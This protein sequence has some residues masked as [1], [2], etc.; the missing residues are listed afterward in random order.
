MSFDDLNLWLITAMSLTAVA[1]LVWTMAALFRR[2]KPAPFDL[3]AEHRSGQFSAVR[4]RD[5]GRR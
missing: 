5:R 1:L 2:S 4:S 3:S